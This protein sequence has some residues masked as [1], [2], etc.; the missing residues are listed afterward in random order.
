MTNT[1]LAKAG[2]VAALALLLAGCAPASEPN[3]GVNAGDSGIPSEAAP[4]GADLQKLIDDGTLPADF[5]AG[6]ER[7]RL[8][9]HGKKLAASWTGE[10][11]G[12]D[13]SAAESS[14]GSYAAILLLQDVPLTDI[15]RCGDVWQATQADG[16]HVLWNS[17][18]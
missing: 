18:R 4:S 9:E 7:V 10:P 8:I 1:W 15:Q 16:S 3:A 13:C 5:P 2:V 6:A 12:A 11:L 17:E 14:P